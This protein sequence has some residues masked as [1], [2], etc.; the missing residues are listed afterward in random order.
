MCS[1]DLDN[2]LKTSRI[3]RESTGESPVGWLSPMAQPGE[4]TAALIAEQ[5]YLYHLDCADDDSPRL[6]QLGERCIVEVPAAFD[7]NDHQVYARGLNPPSAYVDIFMHCLDV[8]LEEGR[9]GRPRVMSAVFN[10]N[11]FGHPLGTWALRE[12]IRYAKGRPGVWI[13]THKA[14]VEHFLRECRQ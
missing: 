8:L 3:I 9:N 13:T 10:G 1:S 11:L 14:H 7:V 4:R 2:I 5:G 6:L 12:C